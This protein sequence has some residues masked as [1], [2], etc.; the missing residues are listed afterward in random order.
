MKDIVKLIRLEG[1]PVRTA[2]IVSALIL[3]VCACADLKSALLAAA[4]FA[5]AVMDLKYRIIP[6]GVPIAI[7]AVGLLW[8]LAF[9]GGNVGN[10]AAEMAVNAGAAIV[11]SAVMKLTFRK[12][13]GMGD[14]KLLAA[15]G[16][17]LPF[18]DLM[19]C[20][21]AACLPA[22]I[23]G[24]IMKRKKDADM[25]LA[26]YFAIVVTAILT[27]RVQAVKLL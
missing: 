17:A 4:L 8:R 19:L 26:P 9:S 20:F 24:I 27:V 1:G 25:P 18:F 23:S 22:G 12:G 16:F 3:A 2:G 13:I 5:A 15:C 7:V 11:A 14:I 10:A 6:N 21:A